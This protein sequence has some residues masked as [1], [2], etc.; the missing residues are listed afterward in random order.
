MKKFAKT[1]LVLFTYLLIITLLAVGVYATIKMFMSGGSV[2][3]LL[4]PI[5]VG[6]LAMTFIVA[7]TLIENKEFE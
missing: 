5:L 1:Y 6:A 7:I 2:L 3:M 4:V